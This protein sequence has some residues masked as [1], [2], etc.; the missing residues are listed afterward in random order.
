MPYKIAEVNALF[1]QNKPNIT[2]HNISL[3]PQSGS[4]RR[5]YRITADDGNYIATYGNNVKENESFI[6]FA[7]HFANQGLSVPKVLYV[8]NLKTCYIQTDLG[9]T[10]LLNYLET[11][12]YQPHVYNK[13]KQALQQLAQLQINGH[14]NLDYTKCLTNAEFGKQAIMADLLYFKYYFL[15]ALKNP[16]NKQALLDDFEALS[17]NLTRTE[18]K[19]FMFRDFQSRN[20]MLPNNNEIKFIDFQG[21][22]LGAPQYDVASLLWQAKANL[23][24]QWKHDLLNDYIAEFEKLIGQPVD[25]NIF[26]NQYN[27]YVLI[28]LLQ[29]M[30]AYGFRGLFER[31]AHFLSSIPLGLQNLK[32]FLENLNIGIL[33]PEL[34]KALAFITSPQ[35][36]QQF[37]PILANS[38]TPLHVTVQSFSYK[39]GLP[40]DASG[41]GGGFIFDCRGIT[42]PGRINDYKHLSGQDAE[43]INYLEQ[44]TRMPNFLNSVFDI[45]DINVEDYIAR[46]F[47]SL[48]I[49]FG[50]TGGQHRSVYSAEQTARHL[51]N[52]YKL[53]VA[54]HHNNQ[55]N[56]VTTPVQQ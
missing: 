29:V 46:G 16:Y 2:I 20:I 19:F 54:L 31:K 52:K 41:N 36:V 32:Y 3:L 12:G 51:R 23:P 8:N 27:G 4:D 13:F 34:K 22:M 44:Q 56:W 47:N 1:V 6:Y 49:N 43:V 35:I 38:N 25:V 10:T 18:Y 37:T 53:N 28:R 14:K 55:Q 45:I 50:C 21:G 11:E 17:N 26:K 39:K 7:Q 9:N 48:Q 42:N 5:Y 40:T 24:N 30:G 15:D 33:V